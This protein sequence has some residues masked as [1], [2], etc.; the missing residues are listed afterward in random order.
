MLLCVFVKHLIDKKHDARTGSH[1]NYQTLYC[2]LLNYTPNATIKQTSSKDFCAVFIEYLQMTKGR[3]TGEGFCSNTQ[4][5]YVKVLGSVF[6]KAIKAGIIKETPLSLFDRRELPMYIKPKIPHLTLDE[7]K[8]LRNTPCAFPEIK[9]AY[10][11]SCYTGLRFSDVRALQW[12]DIRQDNNNKTWVAYRQKKTQKQEYL[13][14]AKP[15]LDILNAKWRKA[16]T[17]PVFGLQENKEV[18]QKLKSFAAA[19]GIDGKKVTFHTAR[20]TATTLL[21]MDSS[22]EEVS[23]ILGHSEIRTTQIYAKVLDK[24]VEATVHRLDN[25][26]DNQ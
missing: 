2:H 1:L 21:L 19:V 3:F 15:T 10:L 22:I 9:E 7:V 26:F 11:F 18:N 12:G 14:L 13:L 23:R 16:D 8:L 20:H 5:V 4:L 6:N 24:Q 25:I 17:E